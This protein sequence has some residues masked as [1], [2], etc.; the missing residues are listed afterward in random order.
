MLSAGGSTL[1]RPGVFEQADARA[2]PRAQGASVTLTSSQLA[3]RQHGGTQPVISIITVV[4]NGA[5]T[6]EATIQSILQQSYENIEHLIIDGGSTD[7][8][9]NIIQRFQHRIA[10][11]VSEKDNGIYDAMNKGAMSAHG[12]W[13]L[14]MNSGDTFC[15]PAV[16]Q[17]IFSRELPPHV[18]VIYGNTV[19]K[20]S[21]NILHPPAK[22]DRKYFYFETLCHQSIFA[23]RELFERIGKFSSRYRIIADREWLFR[24]TMAGGRFAHADVEVCVW[25]AEGFSSA[26]AQVSQLEVSDFQSRYFTRGER[27][28]LPWRMR[29]ENIGRKLSYHFYRSRPERQL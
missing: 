19:R 13:I 25:D 18:D 15:G 26:N 4:Y 20:N 14:F 21:R 29:L 3:K 6:L 17:A 10:R 2:R 27:F 24:V 9:V 23:R 22:I 8:T 12:E 28:L 5:A 11:W 16:L 7:G 1:G